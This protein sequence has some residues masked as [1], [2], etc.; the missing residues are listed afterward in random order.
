[1]N[2]WNFQQYIFVVC[3]YHRTWQRSGNW[4]F[5]IAF[6]RHAI[7]LVNNMIHLTG[8]K[9]FDAWMYAQL[10][11][12]NVFISLVLCCSVLLVCGKWWAYVGPMVIVSNINTTNFNKHVS[13]I[14]SLP[15]VKSKRLLAHTFECDRYQDTN[16]YNSKT[17]VLNLRSTDTPPPPHRFRGSVNLNGEKIRL[18]FQ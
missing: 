8:Q 4:L 3:L 13:F 17:G 6:S 18:Y 11:R 9:G 7:C 15:V 2:L 10:P 12:A 5:V 1:M 16:N 14:S